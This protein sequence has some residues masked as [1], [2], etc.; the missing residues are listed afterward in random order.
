[1]QIKLLVLLLL[2]LSPRPLLHS[3]WLAPFSPF[4]SSFNWRFR[5]QTF[6]PRRKRLHC[7]QCTRRSRGRHSPRFVYFSTCRVPIAT[8][9]QN[10]PLLLHII[11][12]QNAL[13]GHEACA[14]TGWRGEGG[15]VLNKCLYV[16]PRSNPLPFKNGVHRSI[17]VNAGWFFLLFDDVPHY[18]DF[19]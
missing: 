10:K 11:L 6:A 3:F 12:L 19:L 7:R 2:L 5:E 14:F 13:F 15:G 18:R 8:L 16:D 9:N 4:F 1:M 17:N